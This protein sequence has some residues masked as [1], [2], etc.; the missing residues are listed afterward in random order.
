MKQQ[1]EHNY[2]TSD[3]INLDAEVDLKNRINHLEKL[4][5]DLIIYKGDGLNDDANHQID[6]MLQIIDDDFEYC[7]GKLNEFLPDG[8]YVLKQNYV[9]FKKGTKIQRKTDKN[10]CEDCIFAN[11]PCLAINSYYGCHRRKSNN[12]V[13]SENGE[14]IREGYFVLYKNEN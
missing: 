10:T 11:I 2:Y 12:N 7:T 6:N 4:R 8:V 14:L 13:T 9:Q 1:K 5:N 3:R